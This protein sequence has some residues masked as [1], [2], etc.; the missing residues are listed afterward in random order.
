[1][2]DVAHEASQRATLSRVFPGAT[3]AA[4][5][6]LAG[7]ISSGAT[8]WD[9][10]LANGATRS[11]VVRAPAWGASVSRQRLWVEARVLRLVERAGI[12][13]PRLWGLDEEGERLVLEFVE[14]EPCF[15]SPCSDVATAKMARLLANIH[16]ITPRDYDLSFLPRRKASVEHLLS[17][18]PAELDEALEE[19]RV[20]AAL[21]KRPPAT[22]NPPVLLHGDYWPGNLLWRGGQLVAAIDWEESELGDPLA[23][24]AVSRLDLLWAFGEEVMQRFT[25]L[26]LAE[27]RRRGHDTVVEHLPWWDLVAALRPMSHL[28]RWASVYGASP[29]A[30][31]DVT[32]QHMADLHRGFVEQALRCWQTG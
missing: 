32:V 3:L 30:R 14:G 2:A 23:D 11:V 5:Q 19:G 20:R 15:T 7:G 16:D 12:A 22:T 9:V 25:E 24:L 6:P 8:R 4:A 1:M 29:I 13:A 31:P 28:P 21:T 17:H 27:R 18:P 26:W 10:V